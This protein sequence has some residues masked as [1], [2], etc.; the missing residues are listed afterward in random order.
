MGYDFFQRVNK[1]DFGRFGSGWSGKAHAATE[2]VWI[3]TKKVEK[4]A[5]YSLSTL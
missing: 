1:K 5:E 3:L 2:R 4:I